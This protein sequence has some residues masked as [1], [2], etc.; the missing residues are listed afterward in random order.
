MKYSQHQTYTITIK[1]YPVCTTFSFPTTFLAIKVLMTRKQSRTTHLCMSLYILY[2]SF[3]TGSNAVLK[4]ITEWEVAS[5]IKHQL[6]L[7]FY[8]NYNSNFRSTR[9]NNY[10]ITQWWKKYAINEMPLM[11]NYERIIRETILRKDPYR[12]RDTEIN[13]LIAWKRHTRSGIKEGG[14]H[15]SG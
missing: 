7:H 15:Y 11:K 4:C 14:N 5:R 9:G 6:T 12:D 13:G 10:G 8:N 1:P 2:C 3:R